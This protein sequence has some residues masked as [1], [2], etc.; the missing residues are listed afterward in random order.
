MSAMEDARIVVAKRAPVDPIA[1]ARALHARFNVTSPDRINVELIAAALGA[2]VLYGETGTADARVVRAGDV[3]YFCIAREHR[4]TP[5]ARF[6]IGHELGHPTLHRGIDGIDLIHGTRQKTGREHRIEAEADLFASELLLPCALLK[7]WTRIAE[8]ALADVAQ[9]ARVF[10]TSLSA[11]MRKWAEIADAPCAY[12]ESRA[13][14]VTEA[15]RSRGWRGVAVKGRALEVGSAAWGIGRDET[16]AE[17]VVTRV[18]REAWGSGALGGE[19]IEESVRVVGTGA[20]VT[21]LR[22]R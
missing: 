1:A 9:V 17:G 12:V 18:H 19:V 7:P 3:A 11:T 22:H 21:W 5:R 15:K 13:G 4:D 8:P 10:T 20:V 2:Y 6:S 16:L 14:K